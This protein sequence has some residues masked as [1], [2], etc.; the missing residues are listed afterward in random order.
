[1]KF[2]KDAKRRDKVYWREQKRKQRGSKQGRIERKIMCCSRILLSDDPCP[3]SSSWSSHSV[4][5]NSP[6]TSPL[7]HSSSSWLISPASFPSHF[8]SWNSPLP[9]P[10]RSW[11]THSSPSFSYRSPSPY[12]R[13]ASSSPTNLTTLLLAETGDDETNDHLLSRPPEHTSFF[14]EDDDEETE[15]D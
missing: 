7:P 3:S 12:K 14:L 1:M 10:P 6:L 5:W 9:P 8:L 2:K 13:K 11:S 4:S 15:D